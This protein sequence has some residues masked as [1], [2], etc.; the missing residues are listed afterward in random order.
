MFLFFTMI[1]TFV[2]TMNF[3]SIPNII[4]EIDKDK[5][6]CDRLIKDFTH[7]MK[8]HQYKMQLVKN[9]LIRIKKSQSN[10]TIKFILPNGF[11]INHIET[12]MYEE[13]FTKLIQLQFN[14]NEKY[15]MTVL[16][17][18]WESKNEDSL[19]EYIEIAM[20]ELTNRCFIISQH[21]MD[22]FEVEWI[23]IM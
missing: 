19:L 18:S 15:D 11:T 6:Y 3:D 14:Y 10:G 2:A 9:I 7:N 16:E 1:T 17:I 21:L 8:L 22:I 12:V 13:I 23:Q 5:Y 4:Q 20:K